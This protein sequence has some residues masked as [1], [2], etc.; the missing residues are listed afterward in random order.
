MTNDRGAA[1]VETALVSLVFFALITA[2]FELGLVFR[3]RL[4]IN[5]AAWEA[6]R[7][8]STLGRSPDADFYILRNAEHALA[9]IGLKN[10]RTLV[11]YK[12]T[13]PGDTVPSACLTAS[14]TDLC[15]HYVPADFFAE[16]SD[17]LGNPTGKFGCGTLDGAWCP[18]GRETD[19]SVGTDWIGIHLEADHAYLTDLFGPPIVLASDTVIRIEPDRK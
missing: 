7:A 2:V 11:V 13:G 5:S 10:V 6:A 16:K 15:N 8:A 4:S 18:T 14:Q 3:S 1:L 9:P 19:A 17:A 12:A